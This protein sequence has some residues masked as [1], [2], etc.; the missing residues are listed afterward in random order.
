MIKRLIKQNEKQNLAWLAIVLPLA[1]LCFWI[2]SALVLAPLQFFLPEHAY[3]V[4]LLIFLVAWTGYVMAIWLRAIKVI[5]EAKIREVSPGIF[6]FLQVLGVVLFGANILAKGED[7]NF[8]FQWVVCMDVALAIFYLSYF[9]LAIFTLTK[10]PWH[11][12]TGLGIVFLSLMYA[13]FHNPF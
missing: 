8:F 9:L 13:A 2:P 3:E 1:S 5:K 4:L 7:K 10:I 12:I 6:H 11:A